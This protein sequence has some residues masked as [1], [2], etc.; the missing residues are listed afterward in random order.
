MTFKIG[1]RVVAKDFISNL[2]LRGQTG[3]IININNSDD[4][5]CVEFDNAFSRGHSS[6]GKGKDGHC[7]W[8]NKGNFELTDKPK[9]K[10]GDKIRILPRKEEWKTMSPC[11]NNEMLKYENTIHTIERMYDSEYIN[12]TSVDYCW[13]SDWLELVEDE[14]AIGDRVNSHLMNATVIK[15]DP[16]DDT[17]FFV[18]YDGNECVD[19]V[20]KCHFIKISKGSSIDLTI[21]DES[22]IVKE[23]YGPIKIGGEWERTGLILKSKEVKTMSLEEKLLEEKLSA[24]K[25]LREQEHLLERDR[26][27]VKSLEATVKQLKEDLKSLDDMLALAIKK[28]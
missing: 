11:Y 1:D 14:F 7:R 6:N 15:L 23:Y 18:R 13:H 12:L 25:N 8:G 24:T 26:E 2:D 5:M 16:E 4:A 10:V 28:K 19:R 20:Y 17:A 3:K 9:L 27:A 21:H 22:A